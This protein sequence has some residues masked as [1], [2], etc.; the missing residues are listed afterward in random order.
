[1][2]PGARPFQPGRA[3]PKPG[4]SRWAWRP[5]VR[6]G[7][8]A[9]E[10]PAA[11]PPAP[12]RLA[13]KEWMPA[14]PAVLPATPK[15]PPHGVAVG[16]APL[17]HPPVQHAAFLATPAAA[18]IV[19]VQATETRPNTY[20][21]HTYNGGNYVHDYTGGYHWYGFYNGSNYYWTRYYANRWWWYD[22]GAAR[23]D[24]YNGGYWW[25][26]NPSAPNA[27]YVYAGGSYVPYAQ[28]QAEYSAAVSTVPP[29][30]PVVSTSSTGPAYASDVDIPTYQMPVST[31]SYALVVGVESY[32]NLPKADFAARDAET[33]RD[34]LLH[35]GFPE[36]NIIL[37]TDSRA[38]RSSLVKYVEAWLPK[39]V[40]ARSRVFVYFGGHGAPDPQSGTSYL[41]PWDGDP[42]YL[43]D[44]GYPLKRL[45]DKLSA[46]P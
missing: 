16:G 30:A 29:A 45:Y 8:F 38:A 44:T 24:Y 3:G 1:M 23:W 13:K 5:P 34:H 28:A 19:N 46:L 15:S 32:Q 37:L 42:K 25:W 2:R 12:A 22:P 18:A 10:R 20:Y 35:L 9:R 7:A 43:A 11:P 36:R 17:L 26:Q 6:G 21:W 39:R 40:D 33:M 4:A 31:D 27:A 14:K 41:M